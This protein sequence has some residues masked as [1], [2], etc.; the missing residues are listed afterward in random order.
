MK[1]AVAE[2]ERVASASKSFEYPRSPK[3]STPGTRSPDDRRQTPNGKLPDRPINRVS[4]EV[5]ATEKVEPEINRPSL[6]LS[7][8]GSYLDKL[9]LKDQVKTFKHA[10]R[11]NTVAY[12]LLC[13]SENTPIL[14]QQRQRISS[15]SNVDRQQKRWRSDTIRGSYTDSQARTI[16]FYDTMRLTNIN[17]LII[18][19]TAVFFIQNSPY[20]IW[21][22]IGEYD[23]NAR[24]ILI[25]EIIFIIQCMGHILDA[26]L[27]IYSSSKVQTEGNKL[28]RHFRRYRFDMGHF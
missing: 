20:C 17:C 14:S 15:K 24:N 3:K 9:G 16:R 12:G 5:P 13:D 26:P 23:R 19:T 22:I 7:E 10:L 21:Y 1:S 2:N 11:R 18:L 28:L 6:S 8:T 27:Y 25:D 4:Y